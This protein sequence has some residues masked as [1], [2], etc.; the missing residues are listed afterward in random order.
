MLVR[1][2]SIN[3]SINP[4]FALPLLSPNRHRTYMNVD[5][6][7]VSLETVH[8]RRHNDQRVAAHKVADASLLLEALAA[9][10]GEQVELEGVGGADEQ[11]QAAEPAHGREGLERHWPVFCYPF[12]NREISLRGGKIEFRTCI[13]EQKIKIQSEAGIGGREQACVLKYK[14]S[15]Q[16]G[17]GVAFGQSCWWCGL[18]LVQ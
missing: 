10:V 5:Q 18:Y 12:W 17:K 1:A 8:R 11:Q 16:K 9:G 13:V 2:R 6:H 15:P 7:A 3:Q 14:P 4:L